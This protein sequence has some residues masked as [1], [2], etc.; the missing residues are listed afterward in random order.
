[1]ETSIDYVSRRGTERGVP[2]CLVS[3]AVNLSNHGAFVAE[4]L[5]S[6]A[7][8]T[9]DELELVLVDDGSVDDT[10]VEARAWLEENSGRFERA[11]LVRHAARRGPYQA[12]NTGF[13][14]ARAPYVFVLDASD[15]IYPRAIARLFEAAT[16]AGVGAAYSQLEIFGEV[17]RLGD[18]DTWEREL[19]ARGSYV[20]AMALVSKAAWHAVGGYSPTDAGWEAYDLW[21]K[22]IDRG[23]EGI[24]VPELLCRKRFHSGSAAK[25]EHLPTCPSTL[26]NLISRHPWIQP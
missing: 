12:R 7:A 14:F 17:S 2:D 11:V 18:A 6:V 25:G 20:D 10:S 19:F 24:F 4:C 5:S 8:Q 16:S 3:V 26:Q 23:L 21:C 9:H 1:M 15:I 13:A 22:F